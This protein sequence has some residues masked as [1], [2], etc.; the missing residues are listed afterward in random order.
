MGVIRVGADKLGLS[1]VRVSISNAASRQLAQ[2]PGRSTPTPRRD[3]A[4]V[5]SPSGTGIG[6]DSVTL[7]SMFQHLR[8]LLD[9]DPEEFVRAMSA[10]TTVSGRPGATPAQTQTDLGRLESCPHR[11]STG[12]RKTVDAR[13]AG[14]Y[15]NRLRKGMP[16]QADP[17]V[18]YAMQDFG[19]RRILQPQ[20][21]E[22]RVALQYLPQQGAAAFADLHARHRRRHRRR[23]QFRGA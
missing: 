11:S 12:D 6:F 7:F 22:I 16:L 4:G 18:K 23:A 21:P 14:V 1:P 2:A 19:L 20:T 9:G 5:T 3:H 13:I 10:S 8:V 17:T 15:V